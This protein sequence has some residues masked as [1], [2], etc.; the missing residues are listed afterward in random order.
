MTCSSFRISDDTTQKAQVVKL[1]LFANF[2]N[3]ATKL[4]EET[5]T[6]LFLSGFI[7]VLKSFFGA[8]YAAAASI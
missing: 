8:F 3:T 6:S 2:L 7:A 1:G 5:L 4:I